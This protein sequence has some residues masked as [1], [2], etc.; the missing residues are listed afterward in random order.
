MGLYKLIFA[1][2]YHFSLRWGLANG[3]VNA[4]G[5]MH[6]LLTLIIGSNV[7]TVISYFLF[8]FFGKKVTIDFLVN[9]IWWAIDLGLVFWLV[10][11]YFIWKKEYISIVERF[12]KTSKY[13]GRSGTV[14]A[15]SFI[16]VSNL[17]LVLLVFFISKDKFK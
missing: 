7:L 13:R 11:I 9:G 16:I 14:I 2:G 15:I 3:P 17:L 5:H 12:Y 6:A 4:A 1:K 10:H 8:L